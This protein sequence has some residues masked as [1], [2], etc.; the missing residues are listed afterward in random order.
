MLDDHPL[1]IY[2]SGLRFSPLNSLVKK[3]FEQE[4]PSWVKMTIHPEPDWPSYLTEFRT[5][6]ED[7]TVL[8]Y[9]HSG[10]YIAIA[11]NKGFIEI[12]ETVS[13]SL[14]KTRSLCEAFCRVQNDAGDIDDDEQALDGNYEDLRD[15]EYSYPP[16]IAFTKDDARLTVVH[17]RNTKNDAKL[18]MVYDRKPKD[19]YVWNLIMDEVGALQQMCWNDY[20]LSPD[21]SFVLTMS[22]NY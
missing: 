2:S 21:G 16:S 18:I 19:L 15:P 1:Q 4:A 7:I 8:E 17:D 13:G 3:A 5:D 11:D 14:W 6:I 20:K 10:R 12:R 22:G 9:S